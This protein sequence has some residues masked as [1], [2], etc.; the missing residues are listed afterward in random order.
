MWFEN[1]NKDIAEKRTQEEIKQFITD[2]KKAKSRIEGEIQRKK[3]HMIE[4]SNYNKCF[5]TRAYTAQP[6]IRNREYDFNQNPLDREDGSSMMSDSEL[7]EESESEQSDA[8]DRVPRHVRIQ[9]MINKRRCKTAGVM[10][11]QPNLVDITQDVGFFPI[12]EEKK[13][14]K[15][16][17]KKKKKGA[18]ARSRSSSP[19]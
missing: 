14:A 5:E 3:E 17:K 11:S 16:K 13:P 9:Q 12:I 8:S 10:Q 19:K 18:S 4:G 6:G 1:M 2:W 15:K 7:A